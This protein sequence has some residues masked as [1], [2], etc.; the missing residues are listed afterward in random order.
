[1]GLVRNYSGSHLRSERVQIRLTREHSQFVRRVYNSDQTGL[2]LELRAGRTLAT[3]GVKKV[4]VVVQRKNALTHS[5]TL[6]PV[7]SS[8]GQLQLPLFV[9]FQEWKAPQC[10]Y[11]E[12]QE[13]THLRCEH[14]KSGLMTSE[15][16]KT[17]IEEVFKPNEGSEAILL[18]DS[19]PG[20]KKAQEEF[21]GPEK[22]DFLTIPSRTTGQLQPL[23]VFF[24]RQ[25]KAF[26]RRL[27]ELLCRLKPESVVA[28]RKN[29]A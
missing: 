22:I 10:F 25:L 6:Q 1:M 16:T 4:E 29:L 18:V 20:Y 15:L 24:N 27:T 19:W 28:V 11:R 23:D 3:K 9:C 26:H 14:S 5:L 8:A 7:I 2:Q 13:F 12:L 17:W 21:G